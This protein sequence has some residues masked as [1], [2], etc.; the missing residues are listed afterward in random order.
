M[1]DPGTYTP[2]NFRADGIFRVN[3]GPADPGPGPDPD[4]GDMRPEH[5]GR[6]GRPA[7]RVISDRCLAGTFGGSCA[8]PYRTVSLG[9]PA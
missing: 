6:R 8:L 1:E 4:M 9:F 5:T 2:R 7:E 3:P